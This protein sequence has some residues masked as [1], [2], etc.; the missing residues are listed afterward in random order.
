MTLVFDATGDV[1]RNWKAY[2][3]ILL[4]PVTVYLITEILFHMREMADP[5][6]FGGEVFSF[7]IALDVVAFTPLVAVMAVSWHRFIFAR[8]HSSPA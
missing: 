2:P 5:N 4:L 6:A 7:G 8:A 1:T 3:C